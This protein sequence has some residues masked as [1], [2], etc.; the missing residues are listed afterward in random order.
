MKN[1]LLTLALLLLTACS[2]DF[3]FPA[4]DLTLTIAENGITVS[5]CKIM[6]NSKQY[7]T[8]SNYFS[9]SANWKSAPATYLPDKLITGSGF[10]ANFSASRVIIN[11]IY[12]NTVQPAI[13]ESLTCN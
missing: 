11:G 2:S 9:S 8:L 7:E 1:S 5:S 4:E 10:K 3:E 12:K 6:F 13:Y